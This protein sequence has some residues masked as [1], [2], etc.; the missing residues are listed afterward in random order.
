MP[1]TSGTLMAPS[2]LH[3]PRNAELVALLEVGSAFPA[4]AF[5]GDAQV[6]RL[7]TL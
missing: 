6:F 5:A 4:A 7:T 2:A 3:D 1:T